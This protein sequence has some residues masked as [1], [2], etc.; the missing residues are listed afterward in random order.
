[1][2]CKQKS[3]KMRDFDIK[4]D[5]VNAYIIRKYHYSVYFTT[6]GSS[7]IRGPFCCRTGETISS[8]PLVV[9]EMCNMGALTGSSSSS[10]EDAS[11][12]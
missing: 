8:V 9:L 4:T 11:E 12:K 3:A 6:F 7:L 10:W 2:N 5:C 1:M